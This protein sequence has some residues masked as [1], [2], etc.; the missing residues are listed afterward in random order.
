MLIKFDLPRTQVTN[1][2][3]ELQKDADFLRTGISPL[4]EYEETFDA[5]CRCKQRGQFMKNPFNFEKPM[6]AWDKKTV[7]KNYGLRL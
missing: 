7:Y 6:T 1:V 2:T 4:V 5:E 3:T